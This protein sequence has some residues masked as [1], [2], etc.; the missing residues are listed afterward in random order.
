MQNGANQ[1]FARLSALC[2]CLFA[3]IIDILGT[4]TPVAWLSFRMCRSNDQHEARLD[5]EDD[6][7]RKL[8]HEAAPERCV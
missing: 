3:L 4:L 1:D 7:V 5:D 2:I 6:S 8:R